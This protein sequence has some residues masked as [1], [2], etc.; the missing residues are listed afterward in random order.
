MRKPTEEIRLSHVTVREILRHPRYGEG[1]SDV[2][3]II[4]EGRPSERLASFEAPDE[5]ALLLL[6][7]S[8]AQ[9]EKGTT[10]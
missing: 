2:Q 4:N 10:P 8:K 5:V 1:W 9:A 6:L 7:V 3:L